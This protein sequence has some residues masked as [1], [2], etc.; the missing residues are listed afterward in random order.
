MTNT[1]SQTTVSLDSGI[2]TSS[3]PGEPR[4]LSFRVAVPGVC[5]VD[6]QLTG[7]DLLRLFN[8][9]YMDKDATLRLPA[10]RRCPSGERHV[11]NG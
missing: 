9:A 7:D 11:P 10:P 3:S 4:Y 6:L 5:T 1:K 8:G 2:V